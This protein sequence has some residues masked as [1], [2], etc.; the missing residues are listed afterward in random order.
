VAAGGETLH[1]FATAYLRAKAATLRPATI[2]AYD[3]AYRTR[4]APHLGALRLDELTRERLE[5]WLADLLRRDP[6]RRSIEHAVETLCSIL[7]TAAEWNRIPVNPAMRLRMPKK[8]PAALAAERV[9]ALDQLER[10][11]EHAGSL[12]TE[13]LLRVAA[14]AGLRRGE[15]IAL[16]WRDVRLDER[17]LVVNETIWQLPGGEKV[18][19]TPKGGRARRVA[20]TPTLAGQLK[21]LRDESG[22]DLG[23][24]VWPGRGGAPM[25]RGVP[26][27]LLNR[28]QRRAGLVTTE[29][30]PLISLHG[31]RHTAAS[32]GL[33]HGVPLIAVSRQLGHARVDI[34]AKVYAHLLDD[35]QLDAFANAHERTMLREVLREER[36]H[37]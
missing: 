3:R 7:A 26:R 2:S 20:I 33:A 18:S 21:K 32:I 23:A 24:Y 37:R 11:Y 14:E 30:K 34:T 6:R 27:Q 22:G 8:A 19:Q 4:I 36:E 15:I 9:L 28:V 35:S 10:L 16:R 1:A 13:T 31:L 17:R 25:G 5:A 12:R 29:G